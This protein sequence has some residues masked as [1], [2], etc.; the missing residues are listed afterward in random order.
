MTPAF[1]LT[2]CA[3][4]MAVLLLIKGVSLLLHKQSDPSKNASAACSSPT[5]SSGASDHDKGHA[6]GGTSDSGGDG[7]GGGGD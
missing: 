5:D 3:T 7:G 6:D 2:L 4:I 1:I